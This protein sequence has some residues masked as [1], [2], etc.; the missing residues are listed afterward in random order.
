MFEWTV[1]ITFLHP[2][3]IVPWKEKASRSM[4]RMYKRGGTFA[5]WYM[6]DRNKEIGRPYITGTLV[7]SALYTELEN[8][9]SLFAGKGAE[10][11]F[12]EFACFGLDK[13]N[14]RR[15]PV[16]LRK[17]GVYVPGRDEACCKKCPLCL[18]MGR[19]DNPSEKKRGGGGDLSN[20]TVHLSNFREY[21]KIAILI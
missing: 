18:I 16:F 7:R 2:Y 3:R 9:R 11:D 21:T 20:W 6:L 10:N 5:R 19:A 4:D 15:L 8:I 17:R 14:E 1:Q 12:S 13:T